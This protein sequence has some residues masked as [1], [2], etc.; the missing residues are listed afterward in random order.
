MEWF[1]RDFDH[2]LYFEIYR[3][4]EEEAFLEGPGLAA[5]LSLPSGSLVLDLPSGWGRLRPW[6]ERRGHRVV[7]GDLSRLNL[8]RQH[9]EFPGPSVCLDLRAL[10]FRDGCAD[11]VLCAYTSWGYFAT[12]EENLRQLQ[13]YARILRPGGVLLLD[14]AGRRV[15]ERNVA[16]APK[17]WYRAR[18]GYR[19]RVRWSPD[20]RRILAERLLEGEHFRHDIW[21]PEDAEVREALD[22]AGFALDAAYGGLNGSPWEDQA[23]RW[24]YR[25]VRR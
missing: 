18:E 24:I 6:L 5:L 15:V 8:R 3:S 7:G 2:P 11:G 25:A 21:L 10:P 20:G 23:E 1:A 12:E 4:K 9:Q 14:L 17:G 16:E 19:E 13:E 22:A